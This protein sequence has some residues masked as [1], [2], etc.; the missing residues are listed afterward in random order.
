MPIAVSRDVPD[1]EVMAASLG[2]GVVGDCV[3]LE[4]PS[5]TRRGTPIDLRVANV[6]FRHEDVAVVRHLRTPKGRWVFYVPLTPP[7][8]VRWDGEAMTADTL[9]V[10]GPESESV[11]F[12]PRGSEFAVVSVMPNA[13]PDVIAAAGAALAPQARSGAIQAAPAAMR[14]LIHELR[15][16]RRIVEMR[17]PDLTNDLIDDADVTIRRRLCACL[18]GAVTSQRGNG[19]RSSIVR[20]AERL[21]RE[22]GGETLSISQLSSIA[23]VSERS[24]RNAFYCVCTT[25]PKRYLRM[26]RL[27]QVRR[28]LRAAAAG[29]ATVTN[30]ATQH[31]FYEL[32]RFAGEYRALF[33]EAP[34]E[35]LQRARVGFP[36]ASASAITPA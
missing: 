4:A 30:V 6:Q 18:S 32:G 10:E 36:V 5:F 25:G 3:Q 12:E 2:D 14:A 11:V 26:V 27:H 7:R 35:T 31:G 13:A 9:M 20:R 8:G 24:L 1:A 15:H 21:T 29:T 28:S 22:R 19:V 16:V 17:V 23:G 33:G 34:S